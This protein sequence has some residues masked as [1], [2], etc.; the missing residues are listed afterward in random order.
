[1]SIVILGFF[2]LITFIIGLA[3][4]QANFIQLGLDQLFEAPSRYLVLFIHYTIWAFQ[5]GSVSFR[6]FYFLIIIILCSHHGS[7]Q[8]TLALATTI[9][10][11]TLIIV[12]LL[13]GCL[14]HKW[15][16]I[17]PGC[18]NP[19][20]TVYN[21]IN[22]AKSHKHPLQRSA[23]THNDDYIPS[24]LDFA[25]ERFGGPFT[26]EQVEN[27]KTFL[28]MLVFAIGPS[29]VLEVPASYFIFPLFGL[30]LLHYKSYKEYCT[31]KFIWKLMMGSG[32]GMT[33]VSIV[34]LFPAYIWIIFYY[35]RK[36]VPKQF[37][38]L[39]IG[40]TLCLLG[41]VSLL[42]TDIMGH[43]HAL[44]RYSFSNH[45]LC[46]FQ[47]MI[48]RNKSLTYPA[49]NMH[50]GVLIPPTFLLGIGSMLVTA[51]TLEFISGQSPQSMKG[52]L[53][54][55]FFAIRGLFQ[56]LNSIVI[57]PLSLNQPWATRKMI[58]HPPVTNYGFVYLALTCMTGLTGLIL[59]SLA[60]KRYKYRTRDEGMFR[61]HDVEEIFD[62]YITQNEIANNS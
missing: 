33:L 9:L 49:L 21:I 51:T 31:K 1:M 13:I 19:Y 41:V 6:I 24:R 23:F 58:E 36:K 8:K 35:L 18:Q 40:I 28:R 60:A 10:I 38:Q 27:V 57:I 16:H 54:G 48:S 39:G 15:F 7:N 43:T 59:F 46:V 52:L 47:A 30:H 32:S 12:L 2:S 37:A 44:N 34:I 22:Y 29:F 45:S 4:Y 61:Q 56:F 55:V 20:K 25:K 62:R 17:E 14:K 3:G 5:S 42:I 50:W 53:V 26:I 11:N